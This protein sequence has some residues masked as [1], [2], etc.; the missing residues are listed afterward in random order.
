MRHD[1]EIVA[2]TIL[3]EDYSKLAFLQC[4]RY[5]EFH[6]QEG[7][8]YRLRVPKFGR[9][10]AYHPSSCDLYVVGAGC[11][12]HRINVEQGR[13]LNPL[14]T[15]A[16]GVNVCK[17]NP[18]HHLFIC[19]TTEGQ[20]EAWDSRSR[21]P[22]GILDCAFA[23]LQGDYLEKDQQI[24]QI[25][26]LSFRDGLNMAV[27]TSTGHVLLYDIRSSR[28]LLIKDHLYGIPI[29]N[30]LFHSTLDQVISLD[31][32]AVKI[33]DRLTGQPYTSIESEAELNEVVAYEGSGLIFMS[34]EQPKIQVHYIPTLGPAPKWCSF[35]DNITEEIEE[36]AVTAIYD[37]YKFITKD[38]LIDLGLDH[39][40]GSS[41]LRAYMHGYFMDAR[42]Y[43]KAHSIA[44]PYKVD[45]FMK[46]KI[47]KKMADER[48][49]RVQPKS[50]LNLPKT[51]KDLFLKLKDQ[52]SGGVATKKKQRQV[53]SNLLADDRF[54][55]MFTDDRYQVDQNDEAFR[56]LN[57]VLTQLDS[58]KK[59][60]LEKKFSS[61][62]NN[63]NDSEEEDEGVVLAT[64]EGALVLLPPPPPQEIRKNTRR[65]ER[66]LIK[67]K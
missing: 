18:D 12:I 64:G 55:A 21:Q 33:W 30:L 32:K 60:E 6:T 56:L 26:A 29:K 9:D 8:Y 67:L 42:L 31:A 52:E 61:I 50:S 20:V 37:D 36:N 40:V 65:K 54:S 34:N 51:N 2:F 22:T 66:V 24:P 1:S 19:G 25:T 23:L 5:V 7:R 13:F 48:S 45:K 44:Q 16:L 57:P 11:D 46:D 49:K 17:V 43:R 10:L 47:S 53:A 39:L 27:G 41:L 58:E 28:P 59:K 35:L 62:D 4:N 14:T 3:S 15:Q 38:E 63:H